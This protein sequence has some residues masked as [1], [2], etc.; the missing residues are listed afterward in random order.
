MLYS[1]LALS[2]SATSS[3]SNG[4]GVT[5]FGPFFTLCCDVM[6]SGCGASIDNFDAALE[7][8]GSSCVLVE[9]V[10][11]IVGEDTESLLTPFRD[12]IMQNNMFTVSNL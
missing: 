3:S 2:F 7:V 5:I 8:E 1:I 4:A 6:V 11:D 12:D 9:S 10:V